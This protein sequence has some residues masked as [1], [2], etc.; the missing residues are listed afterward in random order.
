MSI[1]GVGDSV[2]RGW[3]N[4]GTISEY[5]DKVREELYQSNLKNLHKIAIIKEVKAGNKGVISDIAKNLRKSGDEN[6]ASVSL[7]EEVY[8]VAL[9]LLDISAVYKMKAYKMGAVARN[10]TSR[11]VGAN[12]FKQ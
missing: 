12:I 2:I 5:Q 3:R 6:V 7:P 9:E 4:D 1:I 10:L 8:K 11:V